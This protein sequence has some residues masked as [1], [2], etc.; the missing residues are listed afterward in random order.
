MYTQHKLKQYAEKMYLSI[1]IKLWKVTTVEAAALVTTAA[2]T[3]GFFGGVKGIHSD[4]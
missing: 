2:H 4:N 1:V 3:K